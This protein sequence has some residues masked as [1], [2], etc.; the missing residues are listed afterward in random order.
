ML[1]VSE[2]CFK[3]V[4][5]VEDTQ[6]HKPDPRVFTLAIARIRVRYKGSVEIIYIGEAYGDFLATRDAGLRFIG[7]VRQEKT[8]AQRQLPGATV[9]RTLDD[10]HKNI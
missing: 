7:A 2:R 10:L 4:Q 9:I 8:R 3:F 5:G 1:R 6:F